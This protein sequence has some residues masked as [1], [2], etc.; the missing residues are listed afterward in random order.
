MRPLASRGGYELCHR[1]RRGIF[2]G[3]CGLRNGKWGERIWRGGRWRIRF[4]VGGLVWEMGWDSRCL[5]FGLFFGGSFLGGGE[6][7]E[8][9]WN[10]VDAMVYSSADEM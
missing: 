5:G 1:L 3:R 7:I 6:G 9:E 2:G 10:R 4:A 8:L